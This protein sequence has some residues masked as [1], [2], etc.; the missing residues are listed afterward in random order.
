MLEAEG[1]IIQGNLQKYPSGYTDKNEK[2]Q[3]SPSNRLIKNENS[4]DYDEKLSN[5]KDT[6]VVE[7]FFSIYLHTVLLD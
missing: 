7:I 6:W 4:D 1:V 2:G 3:I 5:I